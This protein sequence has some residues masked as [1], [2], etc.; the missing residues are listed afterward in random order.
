MSEG[1]FTNQKCRH[2]GSL[3]I[4]SGAYAGSAKVLRRHGNFNSNKQSIQINLF[5]TC[6]LKNSLLSMGFYDCQVYVMLCDKSQIYVDL[7]Q[8]L[9]MWDI[10]LHLFDVVEEMCGHCALQRYSFWKIFLERAYIS[11]IWFLKKL[12]ILFENF[13]IDWL[14]IIRIIL[15]QRTAIKN[16]ALLFKMFLES[17]AIQK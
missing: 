14:Y 3:A 13:Q 4:P 9:G 17:T 15:S 1:N 16:V 5:F 6:T 8:M 10:N 7:Y 2:T 11:L 12:T